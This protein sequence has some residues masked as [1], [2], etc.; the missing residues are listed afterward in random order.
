MF[1]LLH[2]LITINANIQSL[3]AT[4]PGQPAL[5]AIPKTCY[6]I[7]IDIKDCFFSITLQEGVTQW[8]VFLMPAT[9]HQT[10]MQHYQWRVLPQ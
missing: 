3:E 2:D 1:G 5:S 10:P 9:K 4:Q 8:F 7:T 6:K